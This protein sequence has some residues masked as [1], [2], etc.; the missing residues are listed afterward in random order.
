MSPILPRRIG[1]SSGCRDR[2]P[3]TGCEDTGSVPAPRWPCPP[4]CPGR[5]LVL[6]HDRAVDEVQRPVEPPLRGGP[7]LE[8]G[9]DPVPDPRPLPAVEAAGNGL[10]GLVLGPP[11]LF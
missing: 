11:Q 5:V 9:Q 8:F 10:R 4:F 6:P 7:A 2:V 1:P 3:R